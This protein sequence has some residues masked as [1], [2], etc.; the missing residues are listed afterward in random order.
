[1]CLFRTSHLYLISFLFH[2]ISLS[3]RTLGR[4]ACSYAGGP[5]RRRRRS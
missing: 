4:A 2:L 1:M 3:C 5:G